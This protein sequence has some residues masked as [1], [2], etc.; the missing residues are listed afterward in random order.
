[1][2]VMSIIVWLIFGGIAGWIAS[3]IAGTNENQGVVGNI[4]VGIIGAILGGFVVTQFGGREV[5]AG[6]DLY[7]MLVA[8]FGAVILLFGY[9]ALTHR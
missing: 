7:S 9:R 5:S 6:L 2:S 3:I 8:I 4:I 1:M